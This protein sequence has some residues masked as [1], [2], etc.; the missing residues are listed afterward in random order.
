MVWGTN[1]R[2]KK[3]INYHY[4]YYSDDIPVV[5]GAIVSKNSSNIIFY[6]TENS[7]TGVY[8]CYN[9]IPVINEA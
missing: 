4:S 1:G 3:K 5:S 8:T 9:F 6:F 2:A 7:N